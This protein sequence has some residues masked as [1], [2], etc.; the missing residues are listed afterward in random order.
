MTVLEEEWLWGWDPTPGIVSVWAEPDGRAAVWRRPPGGGALVREDARFRP[1]LLLD[2]LDDLRHLG[3]AL[4]PAGSGAP[5]TWRE[6]EG[7][8][9]LRWLVSADRLHTLTAAL[10]EGAGR[11]LGRAVPHVRELPRAE[12]LC[13]PP[14]EQYL[15]A[16]GRTYFRDLPFDALHRLQF[17]L[18]TTGLDARRDR[19]FMI[20]VRDPRGEAFTLEAG[21]EDDAAEAAL[22]ARLVA[23]VTAADPDV[24]ENHNLQGFDLPFLEER[25]RRLGVPLALGRLPALGLR[26]RAARRGSPADPAS[27][28]GR[29]RARYVAPGRELID[30]LDAVWRYDFATRELPGHGLKAVARHL[31]IAAP[32]REYV[33]GR[34]I[35]TVYRRDPERIRRYATDD[36]EEVAALARLLGGAAFALARMAPRR[37]E[38]LADAGAAT[39]VID[40][41][42]VRAYLRAGAALP[43]HEPAD[44]TPHSGAALHLYAAGVARRVVKADVA[45]LYPSLMRAYRIGPERDRLGA[46]LAMVDRLVELRLQAKAAARAAPPGSAER[47]AQEATS[48]AMKLV[49]NS[50]YGYLAAGGELTRFADVHA[51]N[52]VTRRGRETLAV[53]CRALA[54][55]G[56]TLLEADTDGVY[57]AVPEGWSEAD[58]RRVVDEVGALLPPLVQ[59]ELEGRYAAMLSHEPKNYALLRHDGTLL[60]RGV[61][62]RSSR[63]EPYAERFLRDAIARLLADDL[64]GVRDVY[65]DAVGALRRRAVPTHDVSSRVRLTKTPGQ[66]HETRDR[67]RELPYEAML[68][69]GRTTWSPGERVRVYRTTAGEGRL[70][71]EADDAAGDEADPRDYDTEHYARLLRESYATRLARGLTPADFAAVFADPD[72]LSLFATPLAGRHAVLTTVETLAPAA[73][74]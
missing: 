14:D 1:W 61:A 27:G 46:L 13:L 70:V 62:F 29:R 40:P 50:A 45:S 51:A 58:E 2:R 39:G 47:H 72:Q 74:G 52:E 38:R 54:G 32:D 22:I 17:D 65:L 69:A 15:V 53:I 42:L 16:T 35:F 34:E 57:F 37:Y 8:G 7:P 12:L 67:R 55:R 59:L 68:A 21:G 20:A 48:A 30:T 26:Q 36:V 6:L 44:G 33:P 19:I 11:R 60:L 9:A 4:G 23:A 41:L 66:Y 63:I 18:E 56:V 49:V 64:P 3:D 28:D 10:L 5:V 43:A 71:P 24:I 73:G 31:G 25:A